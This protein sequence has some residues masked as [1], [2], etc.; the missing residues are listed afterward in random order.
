MLYLSC[1]NYYNI[2]NNFVNLI[3]I[4]YRIYIYSIMNY[5]KIIILIFF[6]FWY[7]ILEF[8]ISFIYDRE[9]GVCCGFWGYL[10]I[11]S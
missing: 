2:K 11:Y 10:Y 8:D 5:C 7:R 4:R 6:F 3:I 9:N 1:F